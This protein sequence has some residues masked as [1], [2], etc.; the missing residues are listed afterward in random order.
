L[1]VLG[2]LNRREEAYDRR[3]YAFSKG[4]TERWVG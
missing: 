2:I 3:G 4:I 1:L